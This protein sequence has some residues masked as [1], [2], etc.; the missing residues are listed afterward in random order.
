MAAPSHGELRSSYLQ[1][2]RQDPKAPRRETMFE[3]KDYFILAAA[4]GSFA[5]SILLWFGLLGAPNKDAGLFV[6]VWVPSILSL[7]CFA[8]LSMKRR[9]HG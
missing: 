3:K 9:D 5:Y 1:R 6:A 7:G 8:K 2:V 4:L